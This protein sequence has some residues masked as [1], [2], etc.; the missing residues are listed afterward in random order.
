MV[1]PLRR[2]LF[3]GNSFTYYNGGLDNHFRRLAESAVPPRVLHAG[4]ATKGGATLEILQGLGEVHAAIRDG[5]HDRVILQED[6]PELREHTVA[7][8]HEQ[9]RLFD[10]EIRDAGGRPVLFMA[11]PYERLGWVGLETIAEAH[12]AI[13]RE[14]DIPVAPVGLAFQRS[15]QARPG[16]AML[17]P[18]R[19]HETLHGTYLA[20]AVMYGTLFEASPEGLSYR[21]DGV[22]AEEA[23][24][25]QAV[26]WSAV[27]AWAATR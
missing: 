4:R 24:F 27:R 17:G 8:F 19:E 22:S 5:G 1:M 18:D 11:W 6:I 2:I 9:V 25:L 12:R 20:A 14:L 13:G 10:R 15:L 16:L 3:V 23:A 26:A 7:P 21:P